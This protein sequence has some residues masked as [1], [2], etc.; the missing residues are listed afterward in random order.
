MFGSSL[1]YIQYLSYVEQNEEVKLTRTWSCE[2]VKLSSNNE[3]LD[4]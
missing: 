4:T 2:L 1:A 3:E